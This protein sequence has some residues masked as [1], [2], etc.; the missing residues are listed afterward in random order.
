MVVNVLGYGN[1]VHACG[2]VDCKPVALGEN[3]SASE[4]E[5]EVLSGVRIGKDSAVVGKEE[6]VAVSVGRVKEPELGAQ[7]IS[8]LAPDC[9][10]FRIGA[11]R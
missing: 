7:G 6:E 11:Y 8:V 2:K 9:V 10:A 1:A 5:Q 3:K 4:A